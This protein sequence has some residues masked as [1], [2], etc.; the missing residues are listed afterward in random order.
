M[1]DYIIGSRKSN[2]AIH[3]VTPDEA[4]WCENQ[5]LQGRCLDTEHFSRHG[6][7]WRVRASLPGEFRGALLRRGHVG[8]P[9][10]FPKFPLAVVVARTGFHWNKDL[11]ERLF[12]PVAAE[13]LKPEYIEATLGRFNPEDWWSFCNRLREA[14]GAL[15]VDG[16]FRSGRVLP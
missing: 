11:I 5:V 9:R 14:N 1:S 16:S 3:P 12:G 13:F 10:H 4:R 8:V 15:V 2:S 6:G 7:Q